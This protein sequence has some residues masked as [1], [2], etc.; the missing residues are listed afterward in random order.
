[1]TSIPDLSSFGQGRPKL[2]IGDQLAGWIKTAL[3][4]PDQINW[5]VGLNLIP[6]Q[7]GAMPGFVVLL[8]MPSPV[9]GQ[10]L[11]H[12]LLVDLAS[13]AEPVVARHVRDALE[14]LRQQ[15]SAL[16]AAPTNGSVGP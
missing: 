14:Q 11:S 8:C 12:V 13:L 3:T 15:R 5:E 1:M 10:T 2:R 4:G 9:L 7:Q 16:L 6:T